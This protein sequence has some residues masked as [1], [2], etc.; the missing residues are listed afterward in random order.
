MPEPSTFV[1]NTMI[2]GY[3]GSNAACRE[4]IGVYGR[5]RSIG[6]E[7]DSYTYPF[8]LQAC[9]SL[10]D[11][12]G[13]HSLV[14]KSGQCGSDVHAQTSLV[15]FY[16]S[17]GDLECARQVFD[18]MP[19]KNVVSWTVM[20]TGYVKQRQ[21]DDGLALF[22]QMQVLDI[23]PNELTLVNVLSACAHLGA[24]EMGKWVHRYINHKG[25][26]MN[27]TLGTA[28][29]D[30]Y[31]KCGHIH[32]ALQVFKRLPDKSVF[33]WN[34]V[35]GGLAMHGLGEQALEK[36]SE[37]LSIGMRPDDITLLAVLSACAHA[38]LVQKG[39]EYFDSMEKEYGVQPNVK[40][41]EEIYNMLDEM[42][43]RLE[44]EGYMA[45]TNNVI[46]DIDEEDKKRALCHHS[47]KL[48]IAFGLISTKPHTLIR[49][50]KNLRA[51][52]DCHLATKL[53]SKIYNREIIVRD[54]NRFHHFKNGACSCG[55]YW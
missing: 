7:P 14:L 53:I 50:V 45:K 33:A 46:L 39:K 20:V 37:M 10:G 5:M 18:R 52:E 25:I 12:K 2:K 11:G 36:F 43:M 13:V 3:G 38:G 47:E 42:S 44:A 17:F 31:A 24:Y 41:Y 4:G 40:H 27:P 26:A 51:C 16:S 34:A 1:F 19:E 48:A 55:D 32:K 49:V 8:L 54:R 22:H 30:M 28:L 6:V 21:Y 15:S 23:E 35:I 9:A 29:V